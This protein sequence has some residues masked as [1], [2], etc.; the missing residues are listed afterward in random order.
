MT[1]KSKLSV[2][3]QNIRKVSGAIIA[4]YVN[5]HYL[6]E[7]KHLN[8]FRQTAKVNVKRTL[9][10]LIEIERDWYDEAEKIDT[11][12]TSSKMISNNLQFV[13]AFLDFDF[14]DFT[15]LQEVFIAFTLDRKRLVGVSDKILI[16]N[17][18]KK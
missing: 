7:T 2:K 13:D 4:S 18:L 5:L 9:N 12:E 11:N 17:N 1:K 6:Q 14:S 10:D 15:K 3:D 16:D 8:V